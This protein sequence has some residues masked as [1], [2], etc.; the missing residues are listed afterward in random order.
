LSA[1]F[2]VVNKTK[3][4]TPKWETKSARRLTLGIDGTETSIKPKLDKDGKDSEK[5]NA[6]GWYYLGMF[7]QIGFT[8]ALPIAGG[9]IFGKMADGAWNTYPRWTLT[10]LGAG[11]TI[12]LVSFIVSIKSVLRDK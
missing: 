8:I 7:G 4:H 3:Y 12:S 1:S 11:I 9:A 10:G 5:E 2:L 6:E